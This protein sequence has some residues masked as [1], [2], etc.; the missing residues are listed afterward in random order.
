MAYSSLVSVGIVV[1]WMHAFVQL[2]VCVVNSVNVCAYGHGMVDVNV[3][4]VSQ[5]QLIWAMN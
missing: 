4:D 1:K 5:K 2:S 3:R